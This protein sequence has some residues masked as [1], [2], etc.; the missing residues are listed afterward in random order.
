MEEVVTVSKRG[1]GGCIAYLGN[2]RDT[3]VA[4]LEVFAKGEAFDIGKE[5]TLGL[6]S[7]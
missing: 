1:V 7:R 3:V 5:N 6:A 4:G 2:G